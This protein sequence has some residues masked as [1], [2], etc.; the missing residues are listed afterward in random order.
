MALLAAVDHSRHINCMT[1]RVQHGVGRFTSTKTMYGLLAR[2]AGKNDL[3]TLQRYFSDES[4]GI[5]AGRSTIDMM[6]FDTTSR[7]AYLSR[8]PSYGANWKRFAFPTASS[9]SGSSAM[10]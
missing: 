3:A 9:G 5:C 8:G 1:L 2:T 4:C 7:E 6:V 10:R